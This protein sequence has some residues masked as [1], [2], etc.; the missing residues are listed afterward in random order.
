MFQTGD[1]I[2]HFTVTT[3]EGKPF[4][5]RT[6]WQQ[7]NLVLL[8]LP[9][10]DSLSSRQYESALNASLAEFSNRDT[11]WVVTR[12][13]VPGA[14]VPGVV[15]ADQWGEIVHVADGLPEAQGLLE[16]ISYLQHRCPECEGEAK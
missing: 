12:E 10:G 5:Y 14:P 13:V 16:W 11:S 2:P 1:L 3:V 15:I 6:I 7:K 8:T 9:A 4:S